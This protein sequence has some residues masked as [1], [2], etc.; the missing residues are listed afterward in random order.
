MLSQHP[1]GLVDEV[2]VGVLLSGV[3]LNECG[4]IPVRHKADVLTVVLLRIDEA[5]AGRKLPHLVLALKFPQRKLGVC[6]LLLRHGVQHVALVFGGISALFQQPPARCLIVG[7]A[8]VVSCDND[9]IPQH[10]C[11]LIELLELHIAVAVDAGVR[12]LPPLVGV[13]KAPDDLFPEVL[14]EI[15]HIVLH[16]QTI[17]DASCVLRIFQRAAR[18]QPA[19][20]GLFCVVQL[21][22][23]TNA[24][25][26]P[27]AHQRRSGRTVHAAAHGNQRSRLFHVI[28][29]G[30]SSRQCSSSHGAGQIPPAESP[31]HPCPPDSATH[32]R[33]W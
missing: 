23:H 11:P 29:Q 9:V 13:H 12:R 8:G 20:V 4:I 15:E 10:P 19:G 2:A 1:A 7:D 24:L 16:S 27:A 32:R 33:W 14:L 26:P 5:V 22:G 3:P 21:H 18:F 17:G 25:V 6:Q 28:S 31:L 30:G